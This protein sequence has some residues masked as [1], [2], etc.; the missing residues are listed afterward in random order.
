MFPRKRATKNSP[1]FHVTKV[2]K[3]NA[4]Y[5]FELGQSVPKKKGKKAT[6]ITAVI[7]NAT[8][9]YLCI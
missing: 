5:A 7:G 1:H 6:K 9:E 8:M 4:S 2:I 3:L